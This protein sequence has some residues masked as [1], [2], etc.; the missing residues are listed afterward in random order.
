MIAGDIIRDAL[1]KIGVVAEDDPMSADQSSS[2]LRALNRFLRSIQ[3]REPDLFLVASDDVYLTTSASYEGI[4]CNPRKLTSAR[5]VRGGVET[6]MREITRQEYDDLPIKATTGLPSM[7][8]YDRQRCGGTLY[9]W[10]VLAAS[11]GTMVRI[12]YERGIKDAADVGATVDMPSE[13]EEALVYGLADRLADDNGI[14][15]PKVTARAERELNLV[16]A[17]DREGSLFFHD[18]DR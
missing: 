5:L 3:N 11:D 13:W 17:R 6:P 14:D 15:T 9:V 2:G 8:Y 12:T 18:E 4:G 7:W 16:L 10:P 1:R